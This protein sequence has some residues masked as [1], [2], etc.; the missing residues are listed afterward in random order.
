MRVNRLDRP[1]RLEVPVPS[2]PFTDDDREGGVSCWTASLAD[3]GRLEKWAS[4]EVAE[5]TERLGEVG[6]E[7]LP[8]V[9]GGLLGAMGK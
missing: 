3:G 9:L 4:C 6:F 1:G 5:D 7:A 8:E 2:S